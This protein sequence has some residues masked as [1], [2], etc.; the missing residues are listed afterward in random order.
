M[1]VRLE[2]ELTEKGGLSSEQYRFRKRR[3][4]SHAANRVKNIAENAVEGQP[5]KRKKPAV[6]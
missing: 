4:S 6:G 2:K 3:S 1:K 5:D